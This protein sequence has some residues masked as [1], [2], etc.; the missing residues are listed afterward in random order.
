M[1]I[2]RLGVF[3]PNW[4]GDVVMATP[5]L[6][7]VRHHVGADAHI[8]GI[9]R[10]YV[11]D[12][13]NGNPWLDQAILYNPRAQN[14]EHRG[15]RL[16]QR[17]R[18]C[19]L[20]A[21]IN[22]TSSPRTALLAW[23]SGAPVRVGYSR[24]GGWLFLNRLAHEPR[25]GGLRV[26]HSAVD[27]YG[28]LAELIGGD[29]Q[30]HQV[31]ISTSIAERQAAEQAWQT[32]G[33]QSDLPLFGLNTGGAYG[34]AKRW[35]DEHFATLARYLIDRLGG[36]VLVVC[37]PQER[38]AARQIQRLAQRPLL[39][40]LAD[41]PLSIGLTK[42]ALGRC[43]LVVT[44]DSGPRHLAA[45]QGVAT[46]TIFGP[47]DPRWSHNYA[48]HSVDVYHRLPCGPCARRVCPLQHHQCMRDLSPDEVYR[49]VE[50]L[51]GQMHQ[52]AA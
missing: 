32:L 12:V 4:I 50:R 15:W 33:L 37:G 6:R 46:V 13:L 45:A 49:N 31:Q 36:Q 44:T 23:W 16:A 48:P 34:A 10:P 39:Y 14:P 8:T 26:P 20:D 41:Q 40:T 24:R 42:A 28:R 29:F 5:L 3:L 1:Q 11:R 22:L 25:V 51:W 9:V 19:R 2:R 43:D 47:T 18:R 27:H 35:P 21:V 30:D 7:A 52:H 38:E 17:L